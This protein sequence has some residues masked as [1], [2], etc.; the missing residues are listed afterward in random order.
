MKSYLGVDYGRSRIGLAISQ[1]GLLARPLMVVKN[2]GARKN[3][4]MLGQVVKQYEINC[5]VIGLPVH[6]DSAMS[7]EVK[8]F[9]K[10]LEPLGAEIVFQNEMLTS[11][12][13]EE[14]TNDK[15]LIDS[16]AA[17]MILSDYL[18]GGN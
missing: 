8:A 5:I 10:T 11:I 1:S 17:S 14:V 6:K 15:K 4:A 13:A 18:E 9:A 3:L 2:K 16:I 12:A 7:V